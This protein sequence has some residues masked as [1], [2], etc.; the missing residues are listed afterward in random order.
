MA[1]NSMMIAC[2]MGVAFEMTRAALEHGADVLPEVVAAKTIELARQGERD[3]DRLC[4]RALNDIRF[5][6]QG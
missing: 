4:E 5:T 3:P 2:A 6:D 1:N